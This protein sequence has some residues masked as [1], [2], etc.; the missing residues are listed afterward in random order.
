EARASCPLSRRTRGRVGVGAARSAGRRYERERNPAPMIQYPLAAAGTMTRV[1]E[2]GAGDDVVLFVH[3]LGAR[4]DRWR[5]TI[6][7][8]AAAGFRCIAFDLPGHGFA[9]KGGDF[10]YGVPAFGRFLSAVL[11]ALGLDRVF[12]VGTSLGGHVGAW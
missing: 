7:R 4:A 6:E 5:G 11:D 12:I 10:P 1:L 8:V 9:G 2:A 3:G